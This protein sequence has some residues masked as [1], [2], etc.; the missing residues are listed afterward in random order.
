M[1]RPQHN[2]PLVVVLICSFQVSVAAAASTVP[3]LDPNSSCASS[4]YAAQKAQR[5]QQPSS[6]SGES[7]AMVV[8]SGR[9]P[10]NTTRQIKMGQQVT[11][12]IMGLH[13]W[14]YQQK[15]SPATLRLFIGGYLL[16]NIAP[17][18]I[19]PS[20]QEYLNFVLQ[21]DTADSADWKAWAAIVDAA[22]HSSENQL[23][24]SI[25]VADT[26]QVY[27]SDAVVTIVPYPSKWPYLLTGFIVLLAALVY[28]AAKTDLLRSAVGTRPSLPLRSP[29]SLGLVQMAFWFYLVL[30]AYAYICVSTR[31]IHIPMGSVLGLLG[32]SSTTGLAAIFVDKYKDANPQGQMNA[33]LAE[34]ATLNAR[35]K[36]LSL[37]GV[38]PGSAA[39][40]EL[41]QKK[42]RLTQVDSLI[43][44]L[45]SPP[46]PAS[47]S[48]FIQDVLNGGDGISFHR[49]QITIWTIVLGI[50]F[51]WAVYRNM[52]MPEFDASLLTLMGI[53]SGTYV[54]FKVPEKPKT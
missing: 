46:A 17:S 41:T 48:G 32:I 40:T 38:P 37:A 39:E 24:I 16:A 31:Q 14:I 8:V 44:Q 4:E 30:A 53:S 27:E 9:A 3:P 1:Y 47:S 45:P 19:S 43:A 15:K 42:L 34:K 20:N 51:V 35:I 13:D 6:T 10:L 12:C 54:G 25:G 28:M 11:V 7:S 26:K 36:D 50:V 33:L 29:F 21:M 18:S 22:R 5:A 49:F 2:L 52:S 23:P